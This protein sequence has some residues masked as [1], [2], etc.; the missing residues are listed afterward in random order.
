MSNAVVER[1]HAVVD[2]ILEKMLEEKLD[3][4]PQEAP[5]WALHAHNSYP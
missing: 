1:L 4:D 5:G 2:R 3:M